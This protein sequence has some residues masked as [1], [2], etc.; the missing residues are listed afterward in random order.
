MSTFLTVERAREIPV[1][2]G[3]DEGYLAHLAA[4]ACEAVERHCKRRFALADYTDESYCGDGSDTLFLRNFPAAQVQSA[5]IVGADG[6]ESEITGSDLI[7]EASTGRLAFKPGVA[8]GVFPAR[9]SSVRVTYT[10]GFEPV[11]EDVIE[12]AA[13]VAAWLHGKASCEEGL[14]SERLGDYAKT[15]VP[16]NAGLPAAARSL[17]AAY[18]NVRV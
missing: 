4:A 8:P 18:R 9:P 5:V 13:H 2:A 15:F 6:C 7:L 10:A 11:P 17:L 1:L 14:S 16:G 3:A 12:A